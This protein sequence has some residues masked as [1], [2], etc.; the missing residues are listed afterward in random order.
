M[1]LA[2][3]LLGFTFRQL[4]GDT[5][6]NVL[7]YI[8]QKLNDPG[9]ALPRAL[10]RAW[11]RSW[12]TL[13]VALS[14]DSFLER[15]RGL[16]T[17]TN[18]RALQEQVRCFLQAHAD[19]LDGLPADF[20]PACLAE[21]IQAR[22]AGILAASDL[23][24]G[25]LAREAASFQRYASPQDLVCAAEQ[26][27]GA[28]AD[29]LA[30]D[31][32]NLARFIR[33]PG[34]GGPPLLPAVFAY[35]VRREIETDEELAHGLFF[36][37]LRQLSGAQA[38][39]FAEIGKVLAAL[40]GRLDQVL[41]QLDRV[42]GTVAA[43]HGAV[44]DLE[45][46]LARLSAAQQTG[47]DELR[48][49]MRD[50]LARLDRAGMQRGAV[51]AQHSFSLRTEDDRRQVRT[52]ASRYQ[53]L[54]DAQQR[55]VPA[56]L[57]GLG[58]LQVG[59]G[60]FASARQSFAAVAQAAPDPASRA[61]AHHNAYRAA[62]EQQHWDEALAELRQAAALDPKRFAPF[63]TQRYVP[64]RIL[65]AG[66][67]G[68]VFLCHDGFFRN[69][70]VALK[71]LHDAALERGVE[72]V[73]AEAHALS[74]LNHPA[75]VG[76]L[77]CNYVDLERREKPYIVMPYFPGASLEAHLREHGP[78]AVDDLVAVARQV[79]AG[80]K[81]AHDRGILHRDL[82]PDNVLIR[83]QGERWEA[84]IIDF[85]LA[86]HRQALESGGEGATILSGSVAG[87][88]LY[89]PPEQLGRLPGVRPGPHSDVYSFGKLCCYALFRTTE[90]RTRQLSTL[91]R[92]LQDLLERCLEQELEHRLPGFEP[93]LKALEALDGDGRKAEL[94]GEKLRQVKRASEDWER[95]QIQADLHECARL[96][97]AGRNS[98]DHLKTADVE[99]LRLWKKWAEKGLP[100]A[101]WLCAD[102][103]L[104]GVGVSKDV[105]KAVRW[106][107]KA[108][109][110]GLALAQWSLGNRYARGEGVDLDLG[111]AARWYS[112][113][114]EQGDAGSQRALDQ[115][116]RLVREDLLQCDEYMNSGRNSR[117]YVKGVC[118]E[119]LA[120]W[121]FFA[122]R[123]QAEAQWLL[124]DCLLEGVG[125]PKD[126][127]QA[128]AWFR[129]A[130]E[131]NLAL[132]QRSLANRYLRGEGVPRNQAEALRWYRLA[133]AQGDGPAR[134]LLEQLE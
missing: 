32:P 96:I 61:E 37:G 129:K 7:E 66:A 82:K 34:S 48:G 54:P 30:R 120:L 28:F 27:S 94:F 116:A 4:L 92:P 9:Q 86:L 26:A 20:R 95:Q 73:F 75:I 14:G 39:A 15:V 24:A 18:E 127:T 12:H 128:A 65:G 78:L 105:E 132:A 22:K 77:D 67:F 76:V 108:A 42:E 110:Q 79:A 10:G 91:P 36:D 99:R 126:L 117:E 1:H 72:D 35:F 23:V 102:C 87:T 112:R 63:P 119:H 5:V 111:A 2:S 84:K 47:L 85:G 98:S 131:Q 6:V 19:R 123:G 89:A 64:E 81:A 3:K 130:A 90:P 93:V 40:D 51:Q 25:D 44:L 103:L 62:L 118:G 60:D 122:S 101:Q 113:A 109:E 106:F 114:A 17:G 107:L 56:L 45:A 133:A 80:M 46:E 29:G 70:E 68:T 58:K 49:L 16:L 71:A 97:G 8:D 21:L 33:L 57:N 31:Y 124:A 125:V 115:L 11:E 134:A 121:R 38:R 50:V 83:R 100:E 69:R 59:V 52:L 74:E 88:L 43:T 13:A 53:E 55:A 41:D 104:E